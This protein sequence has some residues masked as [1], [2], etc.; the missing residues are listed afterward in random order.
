[1]LNTV[2]VTLLMALVAY[3]A[4]EWHPH[5]LS[6]IIMLAAN[7]LPKRQRARFT[8]EWSAHV[9]ETPGAVVKLWCAIGFFVASIHMF[10]RRQRSLKYRRQIKHG[11][12]A[13][14]LTVRILDL[15]FSVCALV[16]LLPLLLLVTLLVSVSGPVLVSHSRMGQNGRA[17]SLYKFRSPP[18][19]NQAGQPV[20]SIGRFLND[21]ALDELPQLL[22]VVRG[23]MSLVGPRP[24]HDAI[25]SIK[26]GI[27]GFQI[28]CVDRFSQ[29]NQ[30]IAH[31]V[32]WTIKSYFG[33][34]VS[35]IMISFT[36]PDRNEE[37]R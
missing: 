29:R 35:C 12:F 33:I 6:K 8:E 23:E 13:S 31:W 19:R 34:I 24:H 28:D 32:G 14:R 30:S 37:S 7:R 21:T 36:V 25:P 3:E 27:T 18:S 10:P 11:L 1:M 17:F 15:T 16:F 9:E 2:L 5:L 22:N 4:K 26:P 20:W